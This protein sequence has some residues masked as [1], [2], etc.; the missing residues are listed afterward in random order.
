M[1]QELSNICDSFVKNFDAKTFKKAQ[2]GHTDHLPINTILMPAC[3]RHWGQ[4]FLSKRRVVVVSVV[5][6]SVVVV[7]VV[8]NFP[9]KA[10]FVTVL[11]YIKVLNLFRF[12][13][14]LKMLHKLE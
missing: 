13:N 11:F 10:N 4:C 6:V 7:S 8:V 14:F 2:S 9:A 3:Q 5:V 12:E 1:A